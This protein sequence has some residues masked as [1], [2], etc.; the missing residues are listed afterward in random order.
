MKNEFIRMATHDL[1]NPLN[2][3]TG[4]TDL[5]KDIT[6]PDPQDRH[7]LDRA[8]EGVEVSVEKM[9]T[10]VTDLLDLIQVEMRTDLTLEPVKLAN[11]LEICLS[12]FYLMAQAKEVKLTY[13]PPAG[14][15]AIAL[16][17]NRMERVIDNLVSNAIKYTPAGGEV[18]VTVGHEN[19][20]V[21]IRVSDTGLGI[22][23]E[24]LPHLFDAFYRVKLETHWQKEGTGLGLSVVKAVVEQH[25]GEVAVESELGKGSTFTVKLPSPPGAAT[26]QSPPA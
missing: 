5:L 12:G 11:F 1:R 2:I 26:P 10:L 14:D 21:L 22:P 17:A 4:Y 18:R 7:I 25:G 3:I 16:D 19:G 23:A 6:V 15:L 8:I 13:Q 20:Q 24:D 9:R